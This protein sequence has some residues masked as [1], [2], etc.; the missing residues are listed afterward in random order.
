MQT[1]FSPPAADVWN[2]QN[3]RKESLREARRIVFDDDDRE[4]VVQEALLRAYRQRHACR[5]GS[6]HGWLRQITRMEA[7][8]WLERRRTRADREWLQDEVDE[9]PPSDP[10]VD[11]VLARVD[12]RR[13]LSELSAPDRALLTTHYAA[14]L[15]HRE[16]ASAT[17]VPVGTVKV[18]LH[19]SRARLRH[20]LV[21]E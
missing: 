4:E 3:L 11:A 16:I 19:R 8:R 7:L 18:R 20:R 13:A 6:P 1:P 14:G 21:E 15:S 12:V 9:L 10:V 2:W 17:D 5:S